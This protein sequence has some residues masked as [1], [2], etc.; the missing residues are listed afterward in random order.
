MN[1]PI[2]RL[3]TMAGTCRRIVG[4]IHGSMVDRTDC[5]LMVIPRSPWSTCDN[6]RK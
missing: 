4:R 2:R 6:Q 1:N 3:V 5:P